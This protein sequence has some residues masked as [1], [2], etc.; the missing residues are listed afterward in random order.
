MSPH[1]GSI[2]RGP[3]VYG[4]LTRSEQRTWD[5]TRAHFTRAYVDWAEQ[6]GFSEYGFDTRYRGKLD[7]VD[8]IIEN[9]VRVSGWYGAEVRLA[10]STG[11]PPGTLRPLARTPGLVSTPLRERIAELMTRAPELG[12]T[13]IEDDAIVLLLAAQV[14]PE[15]VEE[16]ARD[17]IAACLP[18]VDAMG[19]YR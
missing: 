8:V 6:A 12:A 14:A 10:L 15:R 19:P 7:D 4:A 17:V 11:D 5:A 2:G 18:R 16:L 9:G 13:R 3:G 1:P